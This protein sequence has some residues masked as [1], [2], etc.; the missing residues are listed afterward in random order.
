MHS[1]QGGTNLRAAR[2]LANRRI[3]LAGLVISVGLHVWAFTAITLTPADLSRTAGEP[4]RLTMQS[5]F[6]RSAIEVVQVVEEREEVE[7]LPLPSEE[8]PVVAAAAPERTSESA[9]EDAELGSQ[10]AA[11]DGESPGA[12]GSATVQSPEDAAVAEESAPAPT[13][14]EL[15]ESAMGNRPA[16]AMRPQF[17]AQRPLEG[18]APVEAVVVDPHAGHDHA[19]EDEGSIWGTVWRRMGKTFGFGG[20]KLC[21]PIPAAKA[22]SR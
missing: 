13:F 16:V 6:E 3:L 12:P 17:A 7:P 8:H 18:E 9:A 2:T 11:A 4:E 22:G 10:V 14:A 19:E 15:L 5:P 1:R 21:I 20:D